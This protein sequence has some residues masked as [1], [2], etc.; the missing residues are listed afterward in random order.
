MVFVSLRSS[1]RSLNTVAAVAALAAAGAAGAQPTPEGFLC[2]NL[3]TDGSWIS[4]INYEESHK[5]MI[6]VGTPVKV[7][8]YGRYRVRVELD[9]SKQAIGNDYSRT[10]DMEAFMK[11]YVVAEDP[12]AKIAKFPPK[13][14]EAIKTARLTPGMTREQVIMSVG[15][16]VTSENPNLDAKIWRMW[17]W[18]FSEFQVV[19]GDD[20]RVKEIT[21]DPQ[22]RVKVVMD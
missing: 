19:F 15:W 6:A 5:K 18:S 4:D 16:P 21:T 12:K 9:G 2:C 3:R 8:G 13:I 14:Q 1:I 10:I 11:R 17:L 7:T 22:T 20:G